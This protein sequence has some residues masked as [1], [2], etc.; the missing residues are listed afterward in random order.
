MPLR[1]TREAKFSD[2]ILYKLKHK[3]KRSARTPPLP[4]QW[5]C[6]QSYLLIGAATGLYGPVPSRRHVTFPGSSP[7]LQFAAWN[8][9]CDRGLTFLTPGARDGM[10]CK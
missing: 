6:K 2:S 8:N 10:E 9:R 1:F 7:E 5:T 3:L 4:V